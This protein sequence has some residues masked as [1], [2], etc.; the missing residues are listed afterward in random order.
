MR[1]ESFSPTILRPVIGHPLPTD[2]GE[3]RA[4]VALGGPMGVYES[5]KYPWISDEIRLFQACLEK[6]VPILGICLGS[7][8]LAAAAGAEVKATGVQEIGWG[9]IELTGE[10]ECDPLLQG[11]PSRLHVFHWHGD[12]WDLPEGA[13][14]LA[15]SPVCDHQAFRLGP[16][17]YGFQFHFEVTEETPLTWAE[18]YMDDLEKL[19]E[20]PTPQRM[21]ADTERYAPLLEPYAQQ[22]FRRFW[23][24]VG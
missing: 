12:R 17:A 7:Q 8:I 2:P 14:L 23:E 21:A 5:D 6:E 19:P 20:G 18:A 13:T 10:G 1:P 24:R 15:K 22:V 9:P 4:V 11:L 3:F 16:N